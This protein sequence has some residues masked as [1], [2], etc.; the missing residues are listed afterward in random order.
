MYF[1]DRNIYV[2]SSNLPEYMIGT[3][4][5]DDSV[6]PDLEGISDIHAIP[7]RTSVQPNDQFKDKG[8]NKIGVFVDGVPAYSNVSADKVKQGCIGTFVIINPGINYVNPTVLANGIKL[9]CTIEIDKGKIQS[10]GTE[11]DTDFYW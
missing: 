7:R 6:G 8:Y 11:S 5:T 1:D 10:I 2:A 9:D 4:S 3:F